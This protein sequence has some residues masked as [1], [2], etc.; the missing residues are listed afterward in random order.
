MQGRER[1]KRRVL[2]IVLAIA[3]L[4]SG[5]G[6]TA[7]AAV[8]DSTIT[9]SP[10]KMAT[11]QRGG[12]AV[13]NF[14]ATTMLLKNN[15]N[16]RSLGKN[17]REGLVQFVLEESVARAIL[18]G[19]SATLTMDVTYDKNKR[20]TMSSMVVWGVN[21]ENWPQKVTFTGEPKKAYLTVQCD[22]TKNLTNSQPTTSIAVDVAKY[23]KDYKL[24]T[25]PGSKKVTFRLGMKTF[26]STASYTVSNVKLNVVPKEE[27]VV[28]EDVVKQQTHGNVTVVPGLGLSGDVSGGDDI[29]DPQANLKGF[30]IQY[31]DV[32]T[33]AG[34]F[35]LNVYVRGTSVVTSRLVLAYPATVGLY[36]P[37][38]EYGG[39]IQNNQDFG[40]AFGIP[41]H[42]YGGRTGEKAINDPTYGWYSFVTA[43]EGQP[44]W[45]VNLRHYDKCS[46][47][48]T[49]CKKLF[50][51]TKQCFYAFAECSGVD[52]RS[53][54]KGDQRRLDVFL[55]LSKDQQPR[56]DWSR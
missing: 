2:S 22:E 19:G 38:P 21:T 37:D 18:Q 28:E 12:S 16:G 49:G 13:T 30:L 43:G 5:M 11:V 52:H 53:R 36:D 27:D 32:N 41:T 29:P 10:S 23:I 6:V 1:R 34:I 20:D 48:G 56:C 24:D 50:W 39:V 25:T 8:P 15:D 44:D 46:V 42:N 55:V 45:N 7:G 33:P 14:T 31:E 3:M 26:D 9:V 4:F 51:D 54:G 40:Y 47:Y 35:K 17:T